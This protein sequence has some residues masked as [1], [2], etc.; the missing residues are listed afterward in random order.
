[1][2]PRCP[3]GCYSSDGDGRPSDYCTGCVVPTMKIS[4]VILLGDEEDEAVQCPSC[5]AE[6]VVADE[7]DLQCDNCGFNDL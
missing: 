3:H 7:Y 6:M 4:V 2:I 1:M 5:G